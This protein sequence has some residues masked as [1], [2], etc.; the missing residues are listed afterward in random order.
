MNNEELNSEEL[1]LIEIKIQDI[2]TL[3]IRIQEEPFTPYLS[4]QKTQ[5]DLIARLSAITEELLTITDTIR[6]QTQDL[7]A[8]RLAFAEENQSY[9]ELVQFAT[10]GYI[11]TNTQGVIQQVNSAVANYLN[12]HQDLL[13]GLSIEKF[14]LKADVYCF[15]SN[16]KLL[17]T[18]K[19]LKDWKIS[20]KPRNKEPFP[21]LIF[22]AAIYNHQGQWVGIRWL[23]QDI[24][25]HILVKQLYHDAVHDSLTGLPN[26]TLLIDRLQHLIENYQRHPEQFF[27]V[28]FLDL[29]HFKVLND[30]LGHLAGDQILIETAQRLADCLREVDTVVR[31]GGD[32][33]VILLGEIHTLVDAED[34]AER[35]QH[36]LASPFIA[37]DQDVIIQCSIGI[38]L[39]S[40]QYQDASDILQ[41]ADQAMY[42]AK[43][44]GGDC[45]QVFT[46]QLHPQTLNLYSLEK[47]LRQAVQQQEFEVFYQPIV[48]LETR[49]LSGFEALVRWQHPHKGLRLP[50]S[51]LAMAEETGLIVPI[52]WQVMRTACEQIAQWQAESTLTPPLTV[53]VNLSGQQLAQSDLVEQIQSILQATDLNPRCLTLEITEAV[54]LQNIDHTAATLAQLQA[55]LIQLEI[56]DFGTGFSSLSRLR[57]LSFDGLKIDRSFLNGPKSL[58]IVNI[59][60]KL[61]NNLGMYTVAEGVETLKQAQQLQA[62]G[63]EYAQGFFFGQPAQFELA[64]ET[65]RKNQEMFS[66]LNVD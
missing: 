58:E 49:K 10:D 17:A 47:D 62:M 35:I 19:R 63:C 34:C 2:Q 50:A 8:S 30:G 22:V 28:L 55:F 48:C 60:T 43:H 61:A 40:P 15:Y 36:M 6:L 52:G 37:M 33:F 4:F 32:E 1:T 26:R 9:H 31:L 57:R 14:L 46:S 18:C 59:V 65:V 11:V 23:I 66:Q 64:K 29:D 24:G 12:F 5:E 38:A 45:F 53:S 3:L 42:Q 41:D 56:D 51:F 27:A 16:L 7:H 13:I 21:A 54:L 25:Q 20:L 44:Q 39:S